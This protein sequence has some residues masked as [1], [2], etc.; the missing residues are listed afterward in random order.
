MT[1]NAEILLAAQLEQAGIPFVREVEFTKPRKFRA[2]FGVGPWSDM[3]L[4]EIEGGG[5]IQ[6][7]HSRGLGMERDCEKSALAAIAGYR[8]MRL[9]PRQVEDGKAVEWIRQAL[10]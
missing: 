6:G 10:R 8:V 2:D 3:L 5:F 7:R 4:V 1:S 9:T